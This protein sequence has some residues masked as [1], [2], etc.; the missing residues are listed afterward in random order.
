MP[1]IMYREA[2]RD[3]IAEE[4][5]RDPRV[6]VMGEDVAVYGGAYSATQ[7]LV[8]EFGEER[9]RDTAISEAAIA[10]AATGAAMC[11]MR[12]VA[13]IMYVDFMTLAM[14]Q[15]VNQ[16]AKNRYMFGGKTTVP[17]VL[18]TEGGAGRCI[19]AHHSQSLEAWFVHAPGVFVVMPAT[20]Y[21]AKGLLKT[22]IRDDNPVLFIE[23]KMLYNN[24]GE[25]PSEEYLIPLGKAAVR[26]E[27][28]DVTIVS[29]SRMAL[30]AEEAGKK[31]A[32]EG[33]AAEVIDLRCL[34]PLDLDCVLDSV[35]KTGRLVLASEAYKEGNFVCELAMKVMEHAF[36]LLDAPVERVCAA[37]CPVPMSPV[38]EDECIPRADRIAAAA[39]R[40][41]GKA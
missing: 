6:F 21:D 17:M 31:L 16:A 25:V 30:R 23:H 10:G 8:Q 12:P 37:N 38:L 11:G 4:M 28:S 15:F 2:I 20:P 35:K 26:R 5:R 18:R 9:V 33:I 27:G 36:D 1:V 13:E 19:A 40:T 22:C 7:G 14:D 29:Y 24:K 41:L 32:E 34:K 39:R 3:A